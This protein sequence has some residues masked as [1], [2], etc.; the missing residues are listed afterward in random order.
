MEGVEFKRREA[1]FGELECLEVLISDFQVRH[2]T[3]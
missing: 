3:T 1:S 2:R